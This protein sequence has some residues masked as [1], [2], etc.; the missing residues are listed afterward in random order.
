MKKIH[1]AINGFGRIGRAA[2]KIALAKKGCEIV[3]I[4]DLTS[5]ENLAYLLK[6]D[7][8]YG[9]Y[10]RKVGATKDALVVNGKSFPVLAEKDPSRLPW[11]KIGVDVVLECTGFFTKK[12]GASLHLKAGAKKV[13]IS[14]PTKSEDI[15]TIL[16][17]VNENDLGTDAIISNA[18][19]TTNSIGPVVAVMH[20]AFGIKKALMTTVHAVTASQKIVDGPDAKDFRRGRAA[21]QNMVPTSTGAATATTKAIPELAGLFD[22]LAIRVP[23]ITGS[24]A[25]ITMV[26]GR[27]VHVDEVNRALAVASKQARWKGIL[28]V[29]DEPLVSSDIIGATA[30]SI[31]DLE[32]T[33][34][35]GGD[36]VKV[37]S[38]YDNEWGYANRLVE[39]AIRLGS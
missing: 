13:V 38:W 20:S 36:L 14:A 24:I 8:A 32:L 5:I 34:V 9:R 27:E 29:S 19:C 16:C 11:K 28:E 17:G 22:G 31:V 23:V 18:S 2:F 4:N 39:Q 35:V 15:K 25:D 21:G 10:N 6:Y 3:A 33:R 1:I 12:E 37:V 26:V 7:T 30:S